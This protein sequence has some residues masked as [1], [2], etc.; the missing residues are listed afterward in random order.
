MKT[1]TQCSSS[2]VN[3]KRITQDCIFTETLNERDGIKSW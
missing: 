3:N 1:R 2:A